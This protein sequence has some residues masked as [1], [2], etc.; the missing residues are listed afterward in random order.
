[1]LIYLYRRSD[2][3]PWE[4][5]PTVCCFRVRSA[6]LNADCSCFEFSRAKAAADG[7][8]PMFHTKCLSIFRSSESGEHSNGGGYKDS[9]NQQQTKQNQLQRSRGLETNGPAETEERVTRTQVR[10][11]EVQDNTRTFYK[12]H[13][14]RA[15][16]RKVGFRTGRGVPRASRRER[17]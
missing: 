16:V 14:C 1:M 15:D 2:S 4:V 10:H 3:P 13:D 6:C 9:R 11:G 8:M 5:T 7:M 17:Q 12:C